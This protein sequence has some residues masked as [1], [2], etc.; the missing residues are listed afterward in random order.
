M[1]NEFVEKMGSTDTTTPAP[2]KAAASNARKRNPKRRSLPKT[3]PDVPIPK[4][5]T[6]YGIGEF[7]QIVTT[8][9]CHKNSWHRGQ[10]IKKIMS[11][12][13]EYVK[14]RPGTVYRYIK[15]FEDPVNPKTFQLYEPWPIIGRKPLL[16]MAQVDECIAE[17][18]ETPSSTNTRFNAATIANY[19]ALFAAKGGISLVL[20]SLAKAD[21]RWIQERSIIGS[22]AFIIVVAMTHFYPYHKLRR[23]N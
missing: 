16:T 5:G 12:P 11:P 1:V 7:L 20:E 19:R 6:E 3:I 21:N 10:M 22:M 4:N 17:I 2:T 8:P 13:L 15:E 18:K 9:P 23:L 14:R